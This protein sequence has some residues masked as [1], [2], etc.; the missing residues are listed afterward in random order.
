MPA[1]KRR[2]LIADDHP[3]VGDVIRAAMQHHLPN[4]VLEATDTVDS[5]VHAAQRRMDIALVLLD[6]ELPDSDGFSGFFRMQH[7]LGNVPIAFISAHDQPRVVAAA[8][9][10]GAAG[11]LSKI[12]ELDEITAA[13]GDLVAGRPRFPPGTEV[14]AELEAISARLATLTSAQKRVLAAMVTGHLNKE[15]AAD[16]EIAEATVKTHLSV[17]FRK[18]GA[19]NRMQ[20]V[21][22][23]KA[24]LDPEGA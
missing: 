11:F 21:F 5:A 2:I 4:V 23:V 14:P 16:L 12:L 6:Y 7:V 8:K 15:I 19:A 17:I 1:M 9:A 10:I 3:L 22:A 20:A 24:L 13:I 18:L